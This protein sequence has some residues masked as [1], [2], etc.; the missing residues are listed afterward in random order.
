[1]ISI[2]LMHACM[3]LFQMYRGRHNSPCKMRSSC[4]QYKTTMQH[5]LH[6]TFS[7]A[8]WSYNRWDEARC[9]ARCKLRFCCVLVNCQ[10]PANV[11]VILVWICC[12]LLC[13]YH[14]SDQ[15]LRQNAYHRSDPC[16]MFWDDSFEQGWSWDDLGTT[17]GRPF[18]GFRVATKLYKACRFWLW[19]LE[20]TA[21]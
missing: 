2:R 7:F 9:F 1:M 12:L 4:W 11:P 16:C 13:L 3:K 19:F 5:D 18:Q 8:S 21:N 17:L 15:M 10:L 20:L 6:L 14:G